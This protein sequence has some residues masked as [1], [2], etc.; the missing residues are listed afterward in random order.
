MIKQSGFPP[1]RLIIQSFWFPNLDR[2]K[3]L[4][5]DAETSF[6]A[7]GGG[8]PAAVDER[9]DEWLSAQ[10][11][12]AAATI[13]DAHARGLRV[14]PYTIDARDDIAAAVTGGRGRAD[15]QRPAARAPDRG[16]ARGQAR[17]DPTAAE[18][19]RLHRRSRPPQPGHDRG[20]RLAPP[21]LA[22]VRDAAEAGGSPR[23]H[24]RQL[25]DEDRVHDPR[26]RASAPRARRAQRGGVQRGRWPH[27]ARHGLARGGGTRHR[28]GPGVGVR[29]AGLPLRHGSAHRLPARAL[30]RPGDRL[31]G[32]LRHAAGRGRPVHGGHGHL[33][34]R[35]DAGVLGH[36]EALRR[37]HPRLEQPVALPRVRRPDR[38][39]RF[40]DPD[41]PVP[42]SVY[43][44]TGPRAY[45]EAFIWAPRDV[46]SEGPRMLRNV[47]RA[48]QEG[49][50][51]RHRAG[52]RARERAEH[53]PGR[54]GEPAPVPAARHSGAPRLRHE[55]PG[56]RLRRSAGRRGP[57]LRHVQVLHALPRQ[58]RH[59]PRHA[60]RGEP[61]PLGDRPAVLAAARLDALDLARGVRPHGALRATT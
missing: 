29:H 35:L 33:R 49:A 1:S 46:R 11:P 28:R 20:A 27:H 4:L 14:V 55:P 12:S 57:L 32:A 61:G 58:A 9:G 37:V 34:P 7:L 23:G 59:E 43:V 36:G 50:A 60:G 40:R 5:P 38:D 56:V 21:R 18:Q 53:R 44:A 8:N 25:P 2:A 41:L 54:G 3:A 19:G 51:H 17:A 52:A 15:H 13:A 45:N 22:R 26:A 47:V 16:R 10:W 48:E 42:D 30:R 39:P 24:L 6:L 31:Q